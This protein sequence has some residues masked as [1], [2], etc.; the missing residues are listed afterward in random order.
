MTLLPM[1]PLIPNRI[2]HPAAFLLRN[3]PMTC[4]ILLNLLHPLEDLH[5]A[6]LF[7]V[8]PSNRP[9]L[10]R[11]EL[12]TRIMAQQHGRDPYL[13][14]DLQQISAMTVSAHKNRIQRTDN[15][16]PTP[17]QLRAPNLS[18]APLPS[19]TL[20]GP[21]IKALSIWAESLEMILR[22]GALRGTT[23][24]TIAFTDE[25]MSGRGLLTTDVTRLINVTGTTV[26]RM[27]TL[28]LVVLHLQSTDKVTTALPGTMMNGRR[29][30]VLRITNNHPFRM[31]GMIDEC[32]RHPPLLL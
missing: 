10:L 9:P 13:T 26:V 29:L 30:L 32:H 5:I 7:L 2:V 21:L 14:L 28:V 15:L 17:T 8:A 27:I 24:E 23:N 22:A 20:K 3:R 19:P 1:A 25:L 4:A 31:V 6:A 12:I 16:G 18:S 11:L